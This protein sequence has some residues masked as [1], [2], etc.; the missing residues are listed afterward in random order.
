MTA[1]NSVEPIS[2]SSG[3]PSCA[4]NASPQSSKSG[5]RQ[6]AMLILFTI[7]PIAEYPTR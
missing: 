3:P 5:N 4:T 2:R 7:D 1:A 6:N